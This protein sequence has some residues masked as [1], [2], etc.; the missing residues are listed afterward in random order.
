MLGSNGFTPIPF[1]G[2]SFR[3][4]KEGSPSALLPKEILRHFTSTELELCLASP[5]LILPKRSGPPVINLSWI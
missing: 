3:E 1:E 4:I 2:M 5:P